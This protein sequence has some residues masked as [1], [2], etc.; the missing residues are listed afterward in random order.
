MNLALPR[1]AIELGTT[2]TNLQWMVSV[3]MLA[4]GAF[5]VPAGRI[6]DIFGRRRALLT[7]I[8]LFGIASALCA[9]APSAAFIIGFPGAAGPRGG[10]DLSG[11]GQRAHQRLSRGA[12]QPGDRTRLRHCRIGQCGRRPSRRSTHRDRRLAGNFLAERSPDGH[13]TCHRR[14]Q[15]HRIVGHHRAAPDRSD[16]PGPT[17][18]RN[19]SVHVDI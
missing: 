2:A 6:G 9:L 12:R 13:R 11:V 5:M 1:M 17:N 4:L 16:R 8:A 10:P 15:H 18:R 14:P 19:R 3:Y 7:G